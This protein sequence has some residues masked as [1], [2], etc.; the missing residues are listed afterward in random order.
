MEENKMNG[1][2]KFKEIYEKFNGSYADLI[3]EHLRVLKE[4][5]NCRKLLR[6]QSSKGKKR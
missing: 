3:M 4:L 1:D 5:E 2:K 6:R